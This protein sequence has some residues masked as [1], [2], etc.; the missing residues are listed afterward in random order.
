MEYEDQIEEIDYRDKEELEKNL[1]LADKIV[2]KQYLNEL[3]S[4]M[5]KPLE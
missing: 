2:K 1:A 5:V 4:Y 3:S